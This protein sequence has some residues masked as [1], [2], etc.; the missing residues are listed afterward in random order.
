LTF[1]AA[2]TINF[3]AGFT[4]RVTISLM[5]SRS[6]FADAVRVFDQV[7]VP[8]T[9]V[10]GYLVT[11]VLVLMYLWPIVSW[12]KCT[13]GD[14]PAPLVVRRRTLRAPLVVAVAGYAPWLMSVAIFPLLTLRRFGRWSPELA[15][16]QILSPL[17]NG[18]LAAATTYLVVDWIFRVRVVPVVFRDGELGEAA[19]TSVFGVQARMVVFLIAVAFLPLFTMLGLVRAALLHVQNGV[20]PEVVVAELARGSQL[21]FLVYVL[22]GILLTVLLGR[23]VVRPLGQVAG[24]LQRVQAGDLDVRVDLGSGDELGALAEGVNAMVRA[25]RDRQH[26]LEEFGRVVEPHV[27]DQLLAGSI[28]GS[29]ELRPATVLFCDLRG[30]TALTERHGPAEIVETLNEFFTEMTVWV[31]SCGGFVDKFIGD[32]LLVVFGLFAGDGVPDPSAGASDALRCALG[33]RERLGELNVRRSATGRSALAVTISMHTG[34]VLAGT[35][36]AADR[37]EYT[38]IGDTVNVAARLQQLCKDRGHDVLVSA[39]VA[40]A[41]RRVGVD[42]AVAFRDS[43]ALRGRA[44]PVVVLGVA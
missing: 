4:T 33:M 2:V 30:F 17:V 11:P 18:F 32:A 22:L 16:Q 26:I 3:A 37:H 44:E 24:A 13:P 29:G 31:R 6:A 14:E 25:L 36:G 5:R 23:T 8:A 39:A 28:I 19:G 10:V 40:D 21:T 12:F 41:G 35:I 7:M 15:S 42:V 9:Y 27:R 20:A 1:V 38:V 34:D 43:V